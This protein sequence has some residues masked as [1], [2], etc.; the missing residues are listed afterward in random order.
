MTT[1]KWATKLL[2]LARADIQSP[3][4]DLLLRHHSY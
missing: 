4:Y 2:E 3:A 1:E